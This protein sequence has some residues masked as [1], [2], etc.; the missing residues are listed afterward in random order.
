MRL[1][2]QITDK[3]ALDGIAGLIEKLRW[4]KTACQCEPVQK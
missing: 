3:I 4:E 2:A 1:A